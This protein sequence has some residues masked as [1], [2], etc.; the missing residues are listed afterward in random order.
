M[1]LATISLQDDRF[2][3]GTLSL[4]LGG[5]LKLR[6]ATSKPHERQLT[7]KLLWTLLFELDE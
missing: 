6:F 1:F 5:Y 7:V 2:G 3:E 4:Q